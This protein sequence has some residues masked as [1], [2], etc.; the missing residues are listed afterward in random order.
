MNTISCETVILAALAA[1]DGEEA[2]LSTEQTTVHL[3]RCESCKREIEGMKNIAR[4][5]EDKRDG[6]KQL[7]YGAK[8]KNASTR[9]PRPI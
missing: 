7:I 5:F 3:A 4:L 1:L 2:A 6:S 9:P 8:S